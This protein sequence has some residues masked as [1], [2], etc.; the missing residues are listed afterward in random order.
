MAT[1]SSAACFWKS[2]KEWRWLEEGNARRVGTREESGVGP[3]REEAQEAGE[4]GPGGTI[5]AG[6]EVEALFQASVWRA[7]VA[8]GPGLKLEAV[9][10][11]AA[12]R[13]RCSSAV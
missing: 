7:V 2:S 5:G 10:V 4:R 1:A 12:D 13:G 6:P 9:S 8:Q 11:A 3:R